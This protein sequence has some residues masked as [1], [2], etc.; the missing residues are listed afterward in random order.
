MFNAKSDVDLMISTS[1]PAAALALI[2][3]PY[4]SRTSADR[5]VSDWDTMKFFQ[6][7]RFVNSWRKTLGRRVNI[8]MSKSSLTRSGVVSRRWSS[9]SFTH[10]I[11]DISLCGDLAA[12]PSHAQQSESWW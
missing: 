8:V 10:D 1:D 9:K 6:L 2:P 3:Q 12:G 7:E 4:P 5:V 11:G